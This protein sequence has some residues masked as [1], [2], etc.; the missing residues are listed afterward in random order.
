MFIAFFSDEKPNLTYVHATKYNKLSFNIT[1]LLDI[2]DKNQIIILVNYKIRLKCKHDSFPDFQR[3][4]C[5][6]CWELGN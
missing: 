3:I 4:S 1:S 6:M 2:V 5:W